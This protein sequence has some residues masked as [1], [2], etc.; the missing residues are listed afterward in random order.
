MLALGTLRAGWGRHG[1]PRGAI[2]PLARLA[3]PA[4]THATLRPLRRGR[5]VS[6]EGA[7]ECSRLDRYVHDDPRRAPE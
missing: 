4:Y 7:F 3:R 2:P 6:P 1:S 5:G